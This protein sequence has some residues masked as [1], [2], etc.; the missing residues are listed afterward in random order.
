MELLGLLDTLESMILDGFK[1]PLT[2]KTIVNEDD[3]LNLID[4]IRLAVQGGGDFAKKAITSGVYEAPAAGAER[5]KK[6]PERAVEGRE[7]LEGKAVEVLQQAY[8]IAKEIRTGADGYAD[9]VL[10]NLEATT[11]R[12]LRSIRA[13]RERLQKYQTEGKGQPESIEEIL[14]EKKAQ[15]EKPQK[16]QK[17]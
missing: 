16:G 5:G 2:A 9:E 1:I 7:E 10:L 4:K 8:Q 11:A 3:L 14:P 6:K 17:K 12:I 13:G 15:K